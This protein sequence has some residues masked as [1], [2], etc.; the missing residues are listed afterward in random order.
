MP[1]AS[2]KIGRTVTFSAQALTTWDSRI[3][4]AGPRDAWGTDVTGAAT[5]A[6]HELKHMA[7]SNRHGR[8]RYDYQ[9]E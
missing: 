1:S 3:G 7:A 4:L 5:A 2:P 8:R 6:P 9:T